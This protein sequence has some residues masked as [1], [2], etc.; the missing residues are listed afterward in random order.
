MSADVRQTLFVFF[1][2]ILLYFCATQR[3]VAFAQGKK[4]G[5]AGC[6]PIS[7]HRLLAVTDTEVRFSY[8]DYRSEGKKKEMALDGAE[9]LRRFTL[10]F[11]P[12]G[13]RRM[14]H[15]GIL[16]NAQK[17]KAL[18]ACRRS[19]VPN[20]VAVPKKTRREIRA[21][22]LVKLLDGRPS[23]WCTCCKTPTM[24]RIGVVPPHSLPFIHG[25]RAPPGSM[26]HWQPPATDWTN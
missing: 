10:H 16:S 2:F 12:K 19:L 20:E 13:F 1:F 6:L 25:A 15:Y 8:K 21:Q 14:R 18:A 26:P 3:S 17:G 22:A 7:N 5:L 4:M 11:P 9:F 24:V 23:N